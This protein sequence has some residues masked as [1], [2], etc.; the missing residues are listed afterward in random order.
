MTITISHS[1]GCKAVAAGMNPMD[2]KRGAQAAVEKVMEGYELFNMEG[3]AVD[4]NV[5]DDR[6]MNRAHHYCNYN[7][8]QLACH[9]V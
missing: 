4:E 3:Q 6:L 8:C 2:L 5:V 1:E 9:N 7:T